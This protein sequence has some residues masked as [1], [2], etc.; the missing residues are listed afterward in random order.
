MQKFFVDR[1]NINDSKVIITGDDIKHITKVLRKGIGDVLTVSD[2]HGME[3]EVKI[4]QMDKG[5]IHADIIQKIQSQ[6]QTLEITLYQA[7]PKSDKMDTI[8]QKCTELGIAKIVP[9]ISEYTVVTID[10][11]KFDKKLERWRKIALEACKQCGRPIMPEIAQIHGFDNLLNEINSYDLS[12]LA[13][14]K[15][16]SSIKKLLS[17][18]SSSKKIAVIVGPEGGFSS[19]EVRKI[20]NHGAKSVGLGP[21]IL[22]TETA[23]M[24]ILCIIMYELGDMA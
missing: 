22:R 15:E 6:M 16:N 14:E 3:Y 24:A 7:L 12:I 23:G 17:Q 20:T 1:E 18:S 2:G 13:Y 4:A 11:K 21:R 9:Y 10:D 19:E 5:K 8:I